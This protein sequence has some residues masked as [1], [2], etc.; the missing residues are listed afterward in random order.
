MN[1]TG[2][3]LMPQ[4][5]G[6]RW[7]DAAALQAAQ[8]RGGLHS[9]ITE[10]VEGVSLYMSVDNKVLLPADDEVTQQV[11][12]LSHQGDH[13][14]RSA[15]DTVSEFQRHFSLADMTKTAEAKQITA[16][17]AKCLACIK[18]RTGQSIPRPLWYMVYATRPFEYIH[19]D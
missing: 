19:A 15:K 12:A 16:K 8:V 18:T 13:R 2:D 7:P 5:L 4:M 6:E 9:D 11:I 14:H 10:E 3:D 1:V 17:C